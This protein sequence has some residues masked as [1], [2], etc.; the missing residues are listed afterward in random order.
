[1]QTTHARQVLPLEPRITN[2]ES[3]T[4]DGSKS[5][6]SIQLQIRE[7]IKEASKNAIIQTPQY[8]DDEQLSREGQFNVLTEIF[9]ANVRNREIGEITRHFAPIFQGGHPVHLSLL[10]KT[11]TGKTITLLYLLH[12]IAQLCSEQNIPFQQHHLD[13]CCSA[14]CFR[15]L[16]NL[17]CLMGA[18]K[19]Y[20][21]GISL[22][23]LM[24]SIETKLKHA[25]GYIVVFVDEADNVRTDSDSFYKFLIK[26][27][28]Q[29]IE[30]K[31]ILLFSSNRLNWTE[32]LDPRIK[33]CLKMRELLFDPYNAN[34]LQHIL[35][36][37][38]EKALRPGMVNEG[39]V[40]KIAAYASRT[41]GDARKAVDLLTRSAQLAEKNA[42]TITLECVDEAY[43][44]IEKDKYLVMIRTCPKQ[45][46]AA[47]YAALTGKARGRALHTG[48]AYLLYE[49]FCH[50]AG[51]APLTQRAFTDL[52]SEL[53]MYGFIRAR[54]VS[55]GRYGRTKEIYQSVTPQVLQ[56]MKR[57][58]LTCFDLDG[59]MME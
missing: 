25:K 2:N 56:A 35:N 32:N 5:G 39:V 15:A 19:Y 44:E 12:E 52:L 16:N 42:S 47:L 30:A 7:Q 45:L 9:N 31:L 4:E 57:T 48:D 37:R 43:E 38:V 17:G 14:P 49:R 3:R 18:S 10:G 54:T 50:E 51:M 59:V 36:I 23:D 8:L 41:H 53:D 24:R 21:R 55:R 33:S 26:R 58:I 34:D 29:K 40:P 22:D 27:L 28:P 13:L 46:Q 20:K 1:M 6:N 11:G